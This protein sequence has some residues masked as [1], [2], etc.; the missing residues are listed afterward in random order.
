[1][2]EVKW[3]DIFLSKPSANILVRVDDDFLCSAF[4]HYGLRPAV[5]NFDKAY[6]L[7]TKGIITE[8][9][10]GKPNTDSE[11]ASVSDL[12]AV[13]IHEQANN[14]SKDS[15]IEKS[16]RDLYGL[17]HS[18]FI[19][20]PRGLQLIYA[21]YKKGDYPEC[22]RYFC[23]SKLLPFAEGEGLGQDLRWF[24]P[25]CNDVYAMDRI[26]EKE[27]DFHNYS[28][29]DGGYFGNSWV[30]LFKQRYGSRFEQKEQLKV[31]IPRIFGFRIEHPKESESESGSSSES[32]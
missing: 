10:K 29:I 23:K 4:N 20:K 1:M 17:I 12:N 32:D 30:Y 8:P 2:A 27:E 11:S 9:S 3:I 28:D 25:V 7:I 18:R 26:Y 13:S 24:C 5:K 21:K 19:Q 15:D 31:Y 6:A 16:A 22:P 14:E